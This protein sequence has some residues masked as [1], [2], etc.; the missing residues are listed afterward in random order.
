MEIISNII[1]TNA[2]WNG[3]GA[4]RQ[5]RLRKWL[6]NGR[7]M[8]KGRARSER[9]FYLNHWQAF[10]KHMVPNLLT[11]THSE[12][13]FAYT[14]NPRVIR[15]NWEGGW[16]G[17]ADKSGFRGSIPSLLPKHAILWGQIATSRRCFAKTHTYIAY[18]SHTIKQVT[19]KN[20]FTAQIWVDYP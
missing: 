16:I 7:G 8:Q 4:T 13:R 9:A 20:T 6:A 11:L 3:T 17:K 19:H 1:A 14:V 12:W 2:R 15:S 10:L 18:F 5:G